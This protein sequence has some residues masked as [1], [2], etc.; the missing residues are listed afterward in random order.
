MRV[1]SVDVNGVRQIVRMLRQTDVKILNVYTVIYTEN[2]CLV[3]NKQ[4]F[5]VMIIIVISSCHFD[6]EEMHIRK[7]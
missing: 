4:L 2:T 1:F 6:G 5:I 7:Q 3:T